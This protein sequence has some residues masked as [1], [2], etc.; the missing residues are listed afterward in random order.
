MDGQYC[1]TYVKRG[2]LTKHKVIRALIWLVA[3]AAFVAGWLLIGPYGFIPCIVIVLV[4]VF[5]SPSFNVDYEY[6]YVDGQIDFDRITSGEKRKTMLRLDLDGIE[7]MAPLSSHR[8]DSFKNASGLVKHDFSSQKPDAVL[9]GIAYTEGDKR[10][11]VVFE[12]GEEM[13]ALATRKSPRKV[14]KD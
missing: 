9:Y 6:V 7:M 13:L 11:L 12:P 8:L 4:G 5:I 14:F 2:V 1:E 3:L 10:N